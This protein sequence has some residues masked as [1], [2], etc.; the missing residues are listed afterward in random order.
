MIQNYKSK[1]TK[2]YDVFG[3]KF[4]IYNEFSKKIIIPRTTKN[5]FK[6][7]KIYI[8]LINRNPNPNELK[9]LKKKYVVAYLEKN[10]IIA[11][12]KNKRIIFCE[13]KDTAYFFLFEFVIPNIFSLYCDLPGFHAASIRFSKKNYLFL[14]NSKQGKSTLIY[15]FLKKGYKILG[16]DK[17]LIFLD[18]KQKPNFLTFNRYIKIRNRCPNG[19]LKCCG[20]FIIKNP[21]FKQNL[22]PHKIDRIYFMKFRKNEKNKIKEIINFDEFKKLL[23][24]THELRLFYDK[25]IKSLY[26]NTRSF[27]FTTANKKAFSKID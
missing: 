7:K 6:S 11:L 1:L 8:F 22:K 13:S 10:C 18:K 5:I 2:E 4:K 20:G 12:R 25:I 27:E 21:F 14:A 9:K 17:A 19:L 26:N 16:D 23:K 24:S 3:L 15:H